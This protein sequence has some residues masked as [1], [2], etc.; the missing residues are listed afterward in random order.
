M[1]FSLTFSIVIPTYNRPERL[2]TC[3][4]SLTQLDYPREQFEVIVVDDGSPTPLHDVV[5]PFRDQLSLTLLR[6]PNAGPAKARNTGA[7]AAKGRFL[8]FTDDDCMPAAFWLKTLAAR[9]EQAPDCLIGGHTVNA[10]PQN[11]YSTTSQVLIDY[12]YTY[13]N[14]DAE[15]ARFFASN[16]IALPTVRFRAIDGF[17]TTYP[18]AAAEDR[19]LCDRWLQLGY[20][21][22]YAPEVQVYHAHHLS[23]PSF[24]RQHFNYGRGAFRFHQVRAL[25]QQQPI[26]VEPLSF[27]SD[28]LAYPFRSACEQPAF[29][30]GLLALSQVA[31]VAGFFWE[32]LHQP[33]RQWQFE[34]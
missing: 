12:L 33:Q 19:E 27:Y 2:A 7:A 24:W 10:L 15:H 16:N 28:L 26:R 25:R 34:G 32:R 1:D 8:A 29:V 31:G 21:M 18:R 14:A 9:F 13:Y 17:D 20:P 11:L 5:E 22:I 6:Q 23:L 30:S 4:Q 3:L